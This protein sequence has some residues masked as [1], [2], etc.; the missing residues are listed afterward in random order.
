M[1]KVLFLAGVYW[2]DPIQRYQQFAKY[3]EMC[4][5]KVYFVEHIVSSNFTL[6]KFVDAIKVQK[7]KS[8]KKPNKKP[9]NLIVYNVNFVNPQRGAFD[10]INRKKVDALV[11]KIGTAFDVVINYLPISTTRYIV[12]R[13]EYN[14]LIYDCVRNFSGWG[15]YPKNIQLEEKR[16]IQKANKIFTDSYYLTNQM[17]AKTD[18]EVVQFLPIANEAWIKG[19]KK[20]K[21]RKIKKVAYFGSVAK[22]IDQ[23]AFKV[24]AAEGIEVHIWGNLLGKLDFN[25]IYHGYQNNL[26]I[27]AHQICATA[28]ALILPYAGSMDG[29][30]PAKMLQCLATGLPVYI[31]SFYDSRKLANYIYVYHNYSELVHK[32]RNFEERD[33]E[34][35]KQA[36]GEF[37]K[38]FSEQE[39]CIRFISEIWKE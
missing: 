13:L 21:I 36:A 18:K 7:G 30:I 24:L 10:Y 23:N 34:K 26:E 31:S 15:G 37:I 4:D 8:R 20:K 29:V 9:G 2:D 38:G 28:D 39:Q 32:I 27:L 5:C 19:C 17:K 16:L 1:K 3:L 12:E 11:R 14:L 25:Y 22:H 6:R 33:F 35:K